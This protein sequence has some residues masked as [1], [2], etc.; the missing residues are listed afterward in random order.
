MYFCMKQ[1]V[2]V[3]VYCNLENI[4]MRNKAVHNV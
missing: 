4:I 2:V 3:F 1:C